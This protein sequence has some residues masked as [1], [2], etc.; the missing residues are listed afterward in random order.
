MAAGLRRVH[1]TM[2]RMAGRS[3]T[4]TWGPSWTLA[5]V[6]GCLLACGSNRQEAAQATEVPDHEA[7]SAM[8][9]VSGTRER[10][11][12]APEPP[13]APDAPTEQDS[14]ESDSG[15]SDAASQDPTSPPRRIGQVWNT[16]YVL[17]EEEDFRGQ[18][19]VMLHDGDCEPIEAV[20]RG[21]Y[22]DLCIEGSGKLL[23][24]RVVNFARSCT[25]SCPAAPM[26]GTRPVRIC[27]LALPKETF[28]F[29]M[30]AGVP[31]VPGRSIAVD[32]DVIPLDSWVYLEELDGIVPPGETEPH[33]GCVRAEDTGG[34]I[35]GNHIDI[36]A[37]TRTLWRQW[38]RIFR[39]RSR[40]TAWLDH[41]R[42]A[43]RGGYKTQRPPFTGVPELTLL[44]G[45]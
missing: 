27:Y 33:D 26:C 34:A 9:E 14:T 10:T 13:R 11:G 45:T 35:R 19:T 28:P 15:D 24:G 37:G 5:L 30:G 42:C 38:E 44:D 3:A 23:T 17:S 8:S 36:F 41:P 2:S 12:S 18:R 40:F 29:G 16:Y 32:P 39:T 20:R 1:G 25:R 4:W 21:F 6:G 22:D 7:A 31:L 43:G